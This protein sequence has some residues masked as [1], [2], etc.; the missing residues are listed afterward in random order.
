MSA[1]PTRS[2]AGKQTRL[3]KKTRKQQ[4]GKDSAQESAQESE[5]SSSG[6]DDASGIIVSRKNETNIPEKASAALVADGG[7]SMRKVSDV[8]DEN[9]GMKV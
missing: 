8:D 4:R 2:K 1:E 3:V 5:E 7:S 6:E 9:D